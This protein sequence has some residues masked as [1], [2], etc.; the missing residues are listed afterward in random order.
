MYY[1]TEDSIIDLR[2]VC[3]I[4]KYSENGLFEIYFN[5]KNNMQFTVKFETQIELDGQF[6]FIRKSFQ[7]LLD[8]ENSLR[9]Y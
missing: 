6:R 7:E 9:F 4:N 2:E 8:N 5:M 1:C 3:A